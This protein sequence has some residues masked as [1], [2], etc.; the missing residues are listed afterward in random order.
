MPILPML[1]APFL[2]PKPENRPY[3]RIKKQSQDLVEESCG[4]SRVEMTI[5][6]DLGNV[7]TEVHARPSVLTMVLWK[8]SWTP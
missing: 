3:M 8:P 5:A 1:C 7:W 2:P 6:I 4:R